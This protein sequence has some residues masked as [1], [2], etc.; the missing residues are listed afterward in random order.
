MA[1]P[2]QYLRGMFEN[3]QNAIL[4]ADDSGRYIDANPAAVSLTGYS[5]AELLTMTLVDLTP[6]QQRSGSGEGWK[7]FLQ[8]GRA[9]GGYR[10]LRKDGSEVD[11]EFRAVANIVPGVHL[12]AFTD[13]TERKAAQDELQR[14]EER[15]RS[16]IRQSTEGIWRF[17]L[18]VPADTNLPEDDQV[19]HFYLHAYLAECNDAMAQMYGHDSAAELIGAR[20]GD[21]L[22]R[23]DPSNLKF[24]LAFIRGGYR[25]NEAQSNEFDRHGNAKHFMNNFVGA[26]ENGKLLRVWGVQRDVTDRVL[27]D[28]QLH[29]AKEAA[30][31]ASQAKD[32]F[33]AVLS[34]ELRTPLTPILAI[35]ERLEHS[36]ELTPDVREAIAVIRRNVE[37]EAR[38]VDDLLD[39]TRI[40][41][42]KLE[43]SMQPLDVH[44]KLLNVAEICESEIRE[45]KLQLELRLGAMNHF[46]M[47]DGARLQQVFWNLLKN[48][49]KFTEAGGRIVI[50]TTEADHRLRIAFRDTGIGIEPAVLPHIFEPFEQGEKAI[51]R[52]FGGLG[53]GLTISRRLL[54]LHAGTVRA[55][56]PGRG[57][58]STLIV[59]LIALPQAALAAPPRLS[60]DLATSTL[61]LSILVV[62]DHRD[63]VVAMSRLLTYF[64]HRVQVAES[65]ASALKLASENDFDLIISDIGLPDGTGLDLLSQL[66]HNRKA[67]AIA[68]SGFGMDEDI[69]RSR[70]AG[71]EEHLTKP[72]DVV[73]LQAA[74]NRVCSK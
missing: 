22:P 70:D 48:A 36:S 72:I 56:S 6:L 2:Q 16:F 74:I 66:P 64:G 68:L 19:E 9:S 51:T 45:K 10:V 23:S 26:V 24:L 15:Y 33:M 39:S 8:E 63:T 18:D 46:V 43:L 47:G 59:E 49:I 57:Q 42:G 29:S 35:V 5:R 13:V 1:D 54:E 53:L 73:R 21:M 34:H 55:E 65:L 62:E 30:E 3:T 27:L 71:F 25:L 40:A 61:R 41:R 38:L 32:H 58:G 67:P 31:S 11:I 44:A 20:L 14:S 37:L 69:Q 12:S 60:L 7:R 17:E 28:A 50:Q 4:V 52:H